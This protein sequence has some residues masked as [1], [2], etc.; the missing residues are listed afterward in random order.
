MKSGLDIRT[1]VQVPIIYDGVILDGGL[2]VDL[3][4]NDKVIIEVK[5]V[6]RIT[7]VHHKIALTYLKLLNKKL[8]ILVNFT[9]NNIASAVHRKVNNI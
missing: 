8:A 4:V 5:S 1:E 6:E 9:T 3:L 2:R 7:E